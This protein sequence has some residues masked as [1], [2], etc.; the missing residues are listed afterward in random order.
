MSLAHLR[1]LK[2]ARPRPP[3]GA[4]ATERAATPAA[5]LCG[6]SREPIYRTMD[7]ANESGLELCGSC[8]ADF[9]RQQ[10]TH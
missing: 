2:A 8:L 6:A 1:A 5:S 7:E 4:P 9:R 10:K 3:A